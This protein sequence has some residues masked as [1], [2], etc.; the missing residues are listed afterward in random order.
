MSVS[1]KKFGV[2]QTGE[3]AK[4]YHLENKSG[5]YAE[6][7]DFGAI[8]VK[9]CVPDKEGTLTDVVL[10]YD[11]LASYEVNGCFF[12]A[13]IGRSGNRIGGAKFSINGKEVVLAQNE[14]DNNLHSGPN[15]FEKKLWKAVEISQDK[16]SVV[17]NRISPDGE[18]GYPGE[19]DVSVKYEFTEENELKIHYQGVC[20]EPTIANMTNHSYFNLNGEGSGSAMD[21]YLTLHAKYYTPVA[22]S[23]SIPTGVYEEV[24]G[25]PMDFRTAKKIGQDISAFISVSLEHPKYNEGFIENVKQ[26][27]Q[28]TEC[29]YITGD[30]DFLLKVITG[31]TQEL[32][33]VLNEIKCIHGVSL[34]KT[35]VVLSTM[36]NEY[37]VLPNPIK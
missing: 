19:F 15:G 25:T 12:G 31:S 2:L 8:L 20:D 13:T 26:N 30:F 5:A 29:H 37:S 9:V 33:A 35:L 36:K 10:G 6:V 7:T 27:P 14:N 28:I 23:H 4:I 11:D 32:E 24:A 18:N 34:T 3:S 1:E 21:Q 22:D 16:N 17:F